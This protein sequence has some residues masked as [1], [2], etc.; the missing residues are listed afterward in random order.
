[1]FYPVA[2]K[3]DTTTKIQ[4]ILTTTKNQFKDI[5]V[6]TKSVTIKSLLTDQ[7]TPAITTPSTK[8]DVTQK[9]VE[10]VIFAV[11]GGGSTPSSS[12]FTRIFQ[13]DTT[14]PPKPPVVPPIIPP[15]V[16]IPPTPPGIFALPSPTGGRR[17]YPMAMGYYSFLEKAPVWKPKQALV[18]NI[19]IKPM[20]VLVKKKSTKK[21]SKKAT[22]KTSWGWLK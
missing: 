14:S 3:T 19:R 13:T 6:S 1:M 20:P 11:P 9:L 17:R 4:S 16:I 22:R 15:V 5:G 12:Y 7:V 2:L 8:T 18:G 21:K 10:D